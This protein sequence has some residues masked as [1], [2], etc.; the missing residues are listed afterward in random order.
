MYKLLFPTKDTTIYQR[1]PDR[2]TGVDQ[3]L[4]LTKITSGSAVDDLVGK[5][6]YWGET[7]NSRILIDFDISAISSSIVAGA[8][9][10]P[11]FYL[12]MRATEAVSLPI[13]YT[14]MAHAVSGSWVNGTGYY[15]NN[16]EVTN[17]ASWNYKDGTTSAT[18][19]S[20]LGGDFYT[21]SLYSASQS[22][23]FENPD[24]R[25][26]VTSI[27]RQWL[28]GSIPQHGMIIKHTNL[29]ETGSDVVGSIKFFSKE[30]HT[31]YVPRL[32]VIWE[33]VDVSG[34]GSI[35]VVSGDEYVLYIKN[36]KESYSEGEIA[37]MRVGVRPAY[38]TQSYATTNAYLN[39]YRLPSSSLYSVRDVVTNE[40]IIPFH[41][42]GTQVNCDSNGNYITIDMNTFLPV[43][44]YKIIFKVM[45][46]GEIRYIDNNFAFKVNR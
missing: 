7:L 38:P 6:E 35:S 15:N 13:T 45:N 22:F 5:Y 23:N 26:N 32:E 41:A 28:S 36:L 30:T 20:T 43:R 21:A 40:E 16:F 4:E 27:V 17:G 42:N 9:T 1:H 10:N 34:T 31:I 24:V 44:Y 3:I 25:M 37:K 11:Q 29:T 8:I 46:D 18:S 33:N 2:N 12:N 39:T 19:W 14:L